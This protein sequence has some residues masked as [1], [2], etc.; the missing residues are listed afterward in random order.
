MAVSFKSNDNISP[1]LD[2]ASEKLLAAVKML[3]STEA[4]DLRSYMQ[5]NRPWKDRTGKAKASLNVVVTQ[6]NDTT[7]RI[8][9][10]HGVSYG[11]WLEMAHGG[12]Y[13]IIKP[14]IEKRGPHVM[15]CFDG[16]MAKIF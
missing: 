9:L 16:L 5:K 6:P 4:I 15:Q 10:S 12:K 11:K 2:G 13:G 3:A 14:T 1:A 7:V 8:T